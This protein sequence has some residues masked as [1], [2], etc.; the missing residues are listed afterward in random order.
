MLLSEVFLAFGHEVVR[1]STIRQAVLW[2][3]AMSG[4]VI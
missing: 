2:C 3:W 4:Y 1:A